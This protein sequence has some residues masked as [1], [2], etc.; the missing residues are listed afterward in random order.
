MQEYET[1]SN[2]IRMRALTAPASSAVDG[3]TSRASAATIN[4]SEAAAPD[5]T[6]GGSTGATWSGVHR[7]KGQYAA[8]HKKNARTGT[9]IILHSAESVRRQ[10]RPSQWR[11]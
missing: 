1:K 9:I 5:H 6:D 4:R 8:I 7:N 10:L 11:D 3:A 2:R